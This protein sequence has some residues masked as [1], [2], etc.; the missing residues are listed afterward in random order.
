M[1]SNLRTEDLMV[2][3]MANGDDSQILGKFLYYSFPKLIIDR[4]KFRQL[5]ASMN[6]PISIKETHSKID[7]FKSA[8]TDVKDRIVE[9]MAGE[10]HISRIYFRDNKRVDKDIVSRELVEET[11]N[12]TTNR[13]HKLANIQLDTNTGEVTVT[14]VDYYS[15][16]DIHGYCEQAKRLY[17][18]YQ[19]SVSNREIDTVVEKYVSMLSAIKV[20]ARGHHYFVPKQFMYGIDELEDFLEELNRHNGY[21]PISRNTRKDISVNS[22]YVA[23]DEKQRKK[24][25]EEFYFS[26]SKQ[27]Q[28]YQERIDKLIKNGNQS[29]VILTRW[30]GKVETLERKRYEYEVILKRKLDEVDSEFDYLHSLCDDYKVRVNM[31][32][33]MKMAA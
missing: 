18:L 30:L 5:A 16:R 10:F 26:M 13:Y 23:D 3:K 15:A 6:F 21:I 9:K 33:R 4:H 2:V 14:D 22:M 17:E 8:T 28:D 1:I 27:I 25:A 12:E 31:G 7:A 19:H 24:M 29:E 32:K 20:S 11:L